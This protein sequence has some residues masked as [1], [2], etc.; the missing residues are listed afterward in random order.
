[1]HR[2][3][4]YCYAQRSL[5]AM[6]WLLLPCIYSF[7]QRSAQPGR[8]VTLTNARIPLGE[9]FNI[10]EKQTGVLL[11]FGELNVDQTVGVKFVSTPVEEA[12]GTI[13]PP[14]GL[15]YE[16]V[17]GNRDKIFI[18]SVMPT[19][20][21]TVMMTSI[22]GVVTDEKGE[23]LPGA[24]VR[25]KGAQ[26]AT[27][28]KDNGSFTLNH[29]GEKDVLQ[30]SFMGFVSAEVAVAGKKSIKVKLR[31]GDNSLQVVTA[32]GTTTQ[33]ALTG[34]V[35]VVKGAEIQNL[36]N[37][38]FDKSLQGLVPGL[39]VTSGTGQPG[40]GLSNF[41]LRGIAS[42]VNPVA[43]TTVRNPL[44]II[45][46]M[47][48]SQDAA[49][50][51]IN[52]RTSMTPVSNPIAQINP[53]DIESMSILKDAA[54]I[55]LYGAKASNG[56]IL[57]TTKRGKAGKTQFNFRH[58]TDIAS[59]LLGT[60]DFLDQTEYMDL[61]YETYKNTPRIVNG[62]SMPWTDPEIQEDLKNKFPTRAD[63]SF[64]P[65]PDWRREMFNS[66]ALTVGNEI[67]MSGG[68][69]RSNYYLNAEYTKQNGVVKGTGY[70]RKSVRF[71]FEN[72]PADWVKVGFNNLFSYNVQDYGG[73]LQNDGNVYSSSVGKLSPLLPIR[74]E[75]GNYLNNFAYGGLVNNQANPA[76]VR[77]YNVNRNTAFRTLNKLYGEIDFKNGVRISSNLGLDFMLSE[78][79]EIADPRLKDI[80]S[81]A[82]QGRI[83]EQHTRLSNIITTNIIKYDKII[84]QRHA[85]GFL[86]GQEAQILYR[87]ILGVGVRGQR[88]PYYDQISSPGVSATGLPRGY[89]RKETL[90]SYF[91]Q[92]NYGF[93]NKYFLSGSIR[94][95][96]SSRFGADKRYGVYW[97]A[98]MGWLLSDEAL[99]KEHLSWLNQLKIRGSI[100][101]AG[102][103]SA[104]DRFTPYD[105]LSL[106][107]YDG[108]AAVFPGSGAAGNPDV[109]W[110][111]TFTWDAGIE[112]RFLD[113]R[114][115]LNLDF[116]QRN[117]SNLIYSI[118]LPLNTGF[119]TT[120]ANIGRMR[121]KGI[122]LTFSAD[123]IKNTDFRWN[124]IANWSTNKNT[125]IKADVPAASLISG[126][127]ANQEGHNF[128]SF[129]LPDWGGVNA[130]DGSQ[131]WIDSTGKLTKDYLATTSSFV[132]KSQPDGF[133]SVTNAF[134]FRN[135][136]VSFSLYYQYGFQVYNYNG[137]V[138]DGATPYLNQSKQAK[139]HW[140]KPGDVS[141]NPKPIL[142]NP[143]NNDYFS[144][145][146]LYDGDHI[147]L[148]NVSVSYSLPNV[149]LHDLHI[150]N[151][152]IYL[153]GNNLAL[154][155]RYKD[156]DVSNVDMAGIS[157]LIYPAQKTYSI[158]LNASF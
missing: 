54:A 89:D 63:G 96:G 7:A 52:E 2:N 134:A 51:Y 140:R 111:N 6:L 9:V 39:L 112:S 81:G 42:A 71:N 29:S 154:W 67:S 131:Q 147:R 64:Y 69:D 93:D 37:R 110:E 17:K 106:G 70:D 88:S 56:V 84:R 55:A 128:N 32:Y 146:N 10:I 28:T 34:A 45:D 90:L 18:K 97:S 122:E 5:M 20:K 129:Y 100:G 61:L 44:I 16:Y 118:N 126:I 130:T 3:F 46:G 76:A 22:S 87:K 141:P 98:G 57:I 120:L 50:L 127:I 12:L 77:E 23:P 19:K 21:D 59:A 124:L 158:G 101:A 157:G 78:A 102:N 86:I 33:R 135:I 31:Q 27:A 121:N 8:N 142:N 24:T 115:G 41:V 74:L 156:K 36:P 105:Q 92:L 75:D 149:L 80:A 62:V 38:S 117:T 104:I 114:I 1:M 107:R 144:T 53:S 103:A 139:N 58:Q 14:I 85:I 99:L 35:T 109:K 30:I 11:F 40:G 119:L 153:Q 82:V 65:A 116:Y 72:R 25:I 48:I 155:S 125:L 143:I 133:G 13:L 79:K 137:L 47:P 145:R 4:T 68:N 66:A 91:G 83:E 148:Q 138:H 43:G 95:D 123:V 15:T 26:V 152:K 151:V 73:A 108:S 136:E 49:Q 132:G 113:N 60:N 150:S 94:K